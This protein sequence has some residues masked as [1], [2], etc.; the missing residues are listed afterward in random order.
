MSDPLDKKEGDNLQVVDADDVHLDE[1]EVNEFVE[2][3]DKKV[4]DFG[5]KEN[6]VKS[7]GKTKN[8]N[9]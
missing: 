4:D 3:L 1:N 5:N 7:G 9:N 6:T 2:L 8:S